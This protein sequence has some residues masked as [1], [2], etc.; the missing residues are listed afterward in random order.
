LF[1][2]HQLRRK[3]VS[4]RAMSWGTPRFIGLLGDAATGRGK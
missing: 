3:H 4:P 1:L 2:F